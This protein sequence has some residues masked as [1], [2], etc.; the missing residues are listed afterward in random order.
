MW[1]GTKQQKG[2]KLSRA[3]KETHCAA[4]KLSQAPGANTNYSETYPTPPYS[5]GHQRRTHHVNKEDLMS[6]Y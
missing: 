1:E 4:C 5:P 2:K 6:L 3:K